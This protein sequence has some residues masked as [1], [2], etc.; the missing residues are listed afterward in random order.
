MDGY[1]GTLHKLLAKDPTV[2]TY[3]D[4]GAD[5]ERSAIRLITQGDPEWPVALDDLDTHAP[6]CL[7]LWI[8]G[9]EMELHDP[10]TITGSRAS[11]SYGNHVAQ[12][13]A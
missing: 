11:T 12:Q 9:R 10:V 3:D 4:L 2:P 5:A 6:E 8:A 1:Q 7:A 13:L